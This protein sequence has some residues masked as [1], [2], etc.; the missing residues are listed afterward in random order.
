MRF[1]NFYNLKIILFK[2]IFMMRKVFSFLSFCLNIEPELI[3]FP[4]NT[5]QVLCK[6]WENNWRK[7]RW[8][9]LLFI[10]FKVSENHKLF[11]IIMLISVWYSPW[12]FMANFIWCKTTQIISFENDLNFKLFFW[13]TFQSRKPFTISSLLRMNLQLLLHFLRLVTKICFHLY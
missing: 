11:L 5:S 4:N 9:V 13:K 1:L 12:N 8:Y 2:L 6:P 10:W 3:F 7:I